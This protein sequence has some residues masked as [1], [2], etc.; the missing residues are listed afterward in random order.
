MAFTFLTKKLCLVFV[1]WLSILGFSSLAHSRPTKENEIQSPNEPS[2]RGFQ[3][4]N[5]APDTLNDP[6]WRNPALKISTYR[7]RHRGIQAIRKQ[8]SKRGDM[9]LGADMLD[10]HRRIA[11]SQFGTSTEQHTH[12]PTAANH[13]AIA[14]K[15]HRAHTW[16]HADDSGH[17]RHN[18]GGSRTGSDT[19]PDCHPRY[20]SSDH[21]LTRSSE[22]SLQHSPNWPKLAAPS[23]L[24]SEL[25]SRQDRR[26]QL[27]FPR[28]QSWSSGSHSDHTAATFSARPLAR[29]NLVLSPPR[30][31]RSHADLSKGPFHGSK[32]ESGFDHFPVHPSRADSLT[33]S[34]DRLGAR[35]QII[36][37]SHQ[38]FRQIWM[39]K[40]GDLLHKEQ[41]A[42][43]DL[44]K[45]KKRLDEAKEHGHRPSAH[46]EKV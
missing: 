19:S 45:A 3:T 37:P 23:A 11:V 1:T 28:S 7:R 2:R 31:I 39:S 24:K 18:F 36:G 43:D 6:I 46:E 42:A 16:G 38:V 33:S 29:E 12:E 27:R 14:S 15:L 44:A 22:M 35:A 13:L 32:H 4:R 41:A 26:Q 34:V 25:H 8:P 40:M 21:H 9:T 5:E 30:L 20:S 17:S 10:E